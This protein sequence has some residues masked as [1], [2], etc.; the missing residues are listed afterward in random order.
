MASPT[1]IMKMGATK[2]TRHRVKDW[3]VWTVWAND[4][5]SAINGLNRVELE[6]LHETIGEALR[7]DD[8]HHPMGERN[9]IVEIRSVS[10]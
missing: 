8:T 1:D 4:G 5:A 2:V 7:K 3:P 10:G 9:Q 6:K